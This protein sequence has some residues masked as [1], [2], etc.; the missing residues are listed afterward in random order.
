MFQVVAKSYSHEPFEAE[1]CQEAGE[2]ADCPGFQ[3]E[4]T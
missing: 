1:N 3:Q 2:A 4:D